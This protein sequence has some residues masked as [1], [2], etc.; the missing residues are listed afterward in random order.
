[1]ANL[2]NNQTLDGISDILDESDR[3]GTRVV[4]EL[5]RGAS[6]SVV[7]NNLYKHTSLQSKFSCN[8]VTLWLRT[9][10]KTSLVAAGRFSEREAEC[11]QPEGISDALPGL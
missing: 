7:L 1:V 10:Y 5:K 2:V 6:A 4:V 9:E 3:D 8:M 11:A